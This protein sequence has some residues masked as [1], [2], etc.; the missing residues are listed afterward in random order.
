MRFFPRPALAAACDG[1]ALVLF[2][3]VGLLS[4][5]GAV[6][7]RGLARDALPLLGGWF[8]AAALLRLYARPGPARLAGTWLVGVTGGVVVRATILRHSDVGKE[9]AFLAVS[10]AFTLLFVLAARL[11]AARLAPG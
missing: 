2:A 6:S 4:H 7:G 11:A 9:A 3:V 8:V 10:L 1:A 5:H